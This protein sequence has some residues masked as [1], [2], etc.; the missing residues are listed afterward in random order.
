MKNKEQTIQDE[1]EFHFIDGET[2][3]PKDVVLKASAQQVCRDV[4]NTGKQLVNKRIG[5]D[6]ERDIKIDYLKDNREALDKLRAAKARAK[7]PYI[8]T[9][10]K[11]DSACWQWELELGNLQNSIKEEI[12]LYEAQRREGREREKSKVIAK[13]E[14]EE[15]A[16]KYADNPTKKRQA[17]ARALQYQE[18]AKK[19]TPDPAPG[20]AVHWGWRLASVDSK[21]AAVKEH[22]EFF[23]VDEGVVNAAIKELQKRGETIKPNTFSGITLEHYSWTTFRR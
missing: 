14:N 7:E 15:L 3:E 16:A 6:A 17:R 8:R 19:L 23:D 21:I 2:G 11:I 13:A 22:P 12:A 9:N 1:F 18:E 10:Q 4:I 20:V 5:N